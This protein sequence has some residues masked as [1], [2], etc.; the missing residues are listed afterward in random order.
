MSTTYN[1]STCECDN[2]VVEAHYTV[3]LSTISDDV[4]DAFSITNVT[5]DLVY[6]QL[7]PGSCKEEV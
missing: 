6:G 4:L 1:S 2:F 7:T 5:V 3:Y